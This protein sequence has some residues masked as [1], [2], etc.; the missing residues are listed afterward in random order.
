MDIKLLALDLDGTLLTSEKTV[1]D[2]TVDILNQ[3]V[4]R[5]I[6]V[7]LSTGRL[8]QE[9]SR[10]LSRLPMVR[11]GVF[12]TGAL[13]MNLQT[14]QRL[15]VQT[16]SGSEARRLIG[17]LEGLDIQYHIHD[18]QDNY[19]HGDAKKLKDGYLGINLE[20]VR[21][22]TKPEPDFAAYMASREKVYKIFMA[23]HTMEDIEEAR[24]RLEGEPYEVV[25]PGPD[26]LE[27]NPIASGKDVGLRMLAERFGIKK[28]QIMAIGDS[29]N[30]LPLLRYAGLP[31][32][33]KNGSESAKACAA[34]ITEEDNDHD[35]AAKFIR[36]V[37]L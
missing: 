18:P 25:M 2:H 37:L 12:C 9:C 19:T 20:E 35:G 24:R 36:S 4:S 30:D 10:V 3:V 13:V 14:G 33:M 6:P 22:Y 32:C 8:V 21:S 34:V 26:C 16:V 5:G 29:D 17:R 1:T 11:Y 31:V 15:S 27:I 28:E 23:F 7:V